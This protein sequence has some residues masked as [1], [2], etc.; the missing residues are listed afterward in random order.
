MDK[1]IIIIALIAGLLLGLGVGGIGGFFF[2]VAQMN[3]YVNSNI[4]N[5]CKESML[6]LQM[7]SNVN[8]LS[9]GYETNI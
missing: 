9:D 7:R 2:G 6:T 8:G 1:R 4:D 5:I 3:D